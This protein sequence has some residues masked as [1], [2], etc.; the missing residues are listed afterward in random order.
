MTFRVTIGVWRAADYVTLLATVA[1]LVAW[2]VADY[3]TLLTTVAE[4]AVVSHRTSNYASM[5]AC[6]ICLLK[7]EI[8][9]IKNC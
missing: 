4:S 8:I 7:Y 6:H 5:A 3:P 1:E 2:C 9:A